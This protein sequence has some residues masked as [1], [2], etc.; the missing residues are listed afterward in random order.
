MPPNANPATV[1]STIQNK[2]DLISDAACV[3]LLPPPALYTSSTPYRG[4]RYLHRSIGDADALV[5]GLRVVILAA[6]RFPAVA[7]FIDRRLQQPIA[8]GGIWGHV[9]RI[10]KATIVKVIIM[11][12][13]I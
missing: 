10:E 11:M 9:R 6:L 7:A 2:I 12:A 13:M 4:F 8:Y 5:R 3:P 1:N